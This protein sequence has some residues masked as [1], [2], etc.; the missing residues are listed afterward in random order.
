MLLFVAEET[1]GIAQ[2]AADSLIDF[3]VDGVP[4][5]RCKN[6]RLTSLSN[7]LYHQ[8]WYDI[9]IA[10]NIATQRITLYHASFI[11]TSPMAG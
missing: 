4:S 5:T 3:G 9:P 2:H 7:P 11:R 1:L 10:F 6:V 8:T